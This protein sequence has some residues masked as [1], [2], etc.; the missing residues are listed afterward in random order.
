MF[1]LSNQG[2]I[3]FHHKLTPENDCWLI[4]VMVLI[5]ISQSN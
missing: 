2:V 4:D 5:T 3:L 1:S